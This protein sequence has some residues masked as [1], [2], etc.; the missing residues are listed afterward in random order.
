MII[1][2][3]YTSHNTTNNEKIKTPSVFATCFGYAAIIRQNN[4][5]THIHTTGTAAPKLDTI[6]LRIFLKIL[7]VKTIK[8]RKLI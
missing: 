1:S 2:L 8:T 7:D 3:Y 6:S 4:M 5:I